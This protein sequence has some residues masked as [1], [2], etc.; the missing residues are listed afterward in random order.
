MIVAFLGHTHK[1]AFSVIVVA[2]DACCAVFT[3]FYNLVPLVAFH[4]TFNGGECAD[5]DRFVREGL[6][7]F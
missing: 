6:T 7:H 2:P 1:F 4:L 3:F 5:P